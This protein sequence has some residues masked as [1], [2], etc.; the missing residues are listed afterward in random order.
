M[1]LQVFIHLFI[2]IVLCKSLEPLPVSLM[3]YK[4]NGNEAK[5]FIEY[6]LNNELQSLKVNIWYE[7]LYY[8]SQS[9]PPQTSFI[10]ISF[11]SLHEQFSRLFEGCSKAPLWMLAAFCFVLCQDD[12]KLLVR[13]HHSK[14]SGATDFQSS[15]C[16]ICLICS[17]PS[18]SLL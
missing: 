11:S 1:Q 5:Q 16:A 8:S 3:L 12:P 7:H 13:I 6:A 15:S 4:D 2:C 9:E 18:V 14:R 10:V 17:F